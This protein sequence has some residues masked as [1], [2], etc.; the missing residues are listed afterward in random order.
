MWLITYS[1]RNAPCG[2]DIIANTHAHKNENPAEW[3]YRMCLKYPDAH[4]L[5]LFAVE[6]SDEDARKI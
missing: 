4:T 1:Q 3:L 6:V 2:P 5:L